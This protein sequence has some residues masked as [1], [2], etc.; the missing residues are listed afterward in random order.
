MAPNGTIIKHGAVNILG[1]QEFSGSLHY[2]HNLQQSV[3]TYWPKRLLGGLCT[4]TY[5]GVGG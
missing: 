5:V 2:L 3:I 4:C 1:P